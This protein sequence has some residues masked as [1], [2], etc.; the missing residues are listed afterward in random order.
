MISS[1]NRW[2][3]NAKL[4]EVAENQCKLKHN[5]SDRN[6]LWNIQKN[7]RVTKTG[8]TV[9]HRVEGRERKEAKEQGSERER[10]AEQGEGAVKV[11]RN[12]EELM[13]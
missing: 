3:K 2:E 6:T 1:D 12:E 13:R 9:S 10:R 8:T 7:M 11:E 5:V 4:K